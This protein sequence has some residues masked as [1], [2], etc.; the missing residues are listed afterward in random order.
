MTRLLS[1]SYFG[2]DTRLVEIEV[3]I[4][5]KVKSFEI[6]GMV[7]VAVKESVK[8]IESAIVNSGYHFP[9]K[10]IVVN[11][12]PAG[13]KKVGT[14][15]D[16]PIALGILDEKFPLQYLEESVIIGELSL[17]GKLRPVSGA[18]PI[19][20]EAKKQ[21]LL[22]VLCPIQNYREMSV[23]EGIEVIP[24][25]SLIE[26]ME[27]LQGY[28]RDVCLPQDPEPLKIEQRGRD[29][30]DIRGQESAKR[31]IEIAAAGGHNALMVGP[32]GTGKTMLAQRIS[33]ILPEMSL[34][35]SLE[36]TMIY[37]VAGKTDA[38]HPLVVERPFRNPHH[39]AS[40]V[41]IIGGG[42]IPRPGEVSLAHNGVLFLDE[43]QEFRSNVLQVLRQPMEDRRVT[44]SRAEG[45]V[46]FPARFMLIGAMN[47]SR[48][49]VE[50]E[51]WSLEDMQK[52]LAKLSGPLLDRMDIQIQVSR[53]SYDALKSQPQ[54]EDSATI[55][56]RVI[57]SREIQ[58][59]RFRDSGIYS[60]SE[61]SHR[62]VEAFCK[63]GPSGESL[64]KLAM[65]KFVLSIRTYDKIL[66]IARTI[67]DLEGAEH[68]R[69][70]HI[71]EA[72]QYRVLDRI[73]NFI[74]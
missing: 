42:R 23:V 20:L 2:L 9:G 65:D 48:K 58:Q 74:M 15:F 35:E 34:D 63:L 29:M 45:T 28:N 67:A 50:L 55:R 38:R 31:A 13:V 12:A 53:M 73:L 19:A 5:T 16:L 30:K 24:L 51:N 21:G 57:R 14:L 44:I 37:S 18:L 10:K 47:P 43:F 39:T 49:N 26:A 41:S 66:K 60:N 68:I 11:L 1:A 52:V 22:K 8:R 4:V 6:V 70:E 7:G 59:E 54:G 25:D 62:Q 33:G 61:M 40:D 32:P 27:Y 72:L 56:S 71:S 36:T 3:D 64:L 17:D 69:D 46:D